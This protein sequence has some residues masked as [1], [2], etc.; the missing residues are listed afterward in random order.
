MWGEGKYITLAPINFVVE[1]DS[2]YGCTQMVPEFTAGVDDF[3]SDGSGY[4]DGST[5]DMP[6]W[7]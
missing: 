6:D 3:T 5:L 2:D 7:L 4:D 1:L